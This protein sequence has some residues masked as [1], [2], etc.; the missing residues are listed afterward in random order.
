MVLVFKLLIDE[1]QDI[2]HWC[3]KLVFLV[4]HIQVLII[5]FIKILP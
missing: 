1:K 4:S 2:E 3:S 5:V